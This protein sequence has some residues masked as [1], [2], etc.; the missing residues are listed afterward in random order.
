MAF[1]DVTKQFNI[2]NQCRRYGLPLWQCPTFLFLIMGFVI[3][4]SIILAYII[5]TRYIED[6]ATVTLIIL[7][8]AT[9][10]FIMAFTITNSFEKLAEVS[11]MKSEFISVVS[12]QLRSPLTNLKWAIDLIM[13]G[14]LGKIEEQQVEYF[15]IL[16]EN[17]ER[18]MELVEDL[19]YVSRIETATLSQRK[20]EI[21]LVD[22]IEK[23][24]LR[25]EPFAKASNI[26][27][28]FNFEK[29][30]PLAFVDPDQMK[31]VV[32]NL[33]DNAI[34]Y[35]KRGGKIDISLSKRNSFF[36]FEIK[37][38]GI[39]IPQE[40]QKYI[41]QKFFRS[42]NVLKYQTQGSGLGLFIVKSVI[43]RS[44][45]K[46]G[47]KSQEGQGTTFWFTLPITNN[48]KI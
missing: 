19:L 41:F 1:K 23:M 4:V 22:L 39:G 17:N 3:I 37:D 21:S 11:R 36:Y 30:L 47:F 16:K 34:R 2:F 24:I 6:P 28:N 29:N 15:K 42:K 35:I 27:I 8:L 20:S 12:H 9:I 44:G 32:E 40:D 13:S 38:N 48:N 26:K 5:G 18:M 46:V 14:E 33:I 10:L 45:G 25:F 43:E 7:G 31:Q